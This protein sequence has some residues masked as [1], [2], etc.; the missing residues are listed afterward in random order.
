MFMNFIFL[1][2]TSTTH[3]LPGTALPNHILPKEM[4][5]SR[6]LSQRQEGRM[7]AVPL[8]RTYVQVLTWGFQFKDTKNLN[9][10]VAVRNASFV[11]V[12]HL[13]LVSGNNGYDMDMMRTREIQGWGRNC[14][15]NFGHCWIRVEHD[16]ILYTFVKKGH[17]DPSRNCWWN[18]CACA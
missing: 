4:P 10:M 7:I 1:S 6:E 2:G 5:L 11:F 16:G 18:R 12:C 8:S 17:C 15:E 9:G 3:F 13:K 14:I